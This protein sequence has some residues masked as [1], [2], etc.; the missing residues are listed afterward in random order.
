M[1]VTILDQFRHL[2]FD[3]LR[4]LKV[5]CDGGIGLIIYDFL[6]IFSGNIWPNSAPLR[7]ISF[8]NLTLTVTLKGH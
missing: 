5:K 2:H 3:P 7:D 8:Q 1:H 4:S 6:L